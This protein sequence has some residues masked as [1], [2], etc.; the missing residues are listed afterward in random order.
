MKTEWLHRSNNDWL[1]LF[2]NG[3][4]MDS[5]PFRPLMS[6][7]YDVLCCYDYSDGLCRID[8]KN[9]AQKYNRI[10]LVGW[11]MGVVYGQK[12][13]ED[14]ADY[15][16]KT[17]AVNGTLLPVDEL[18]GIPVDI[19][20]ATLEALDEETSLKFYRRMFRPASVFE[21]FMNNRPQRAIDDIKNELA[22]IMTDLQKTDWESSIYTDIL[23]SDKDMIIPTKNQLRFWTKAKAR[24]VKRLESGHFPFYLWN[25]WDDLLDYAG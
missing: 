10:H 18:Y 5:I 6:R 24:E 14:V 19:C 8:I 23:I 22:A 9:L 4:G 21:T 25:S 1:I 17:I 20:R 16:N 11:S 12:H 15:F 2:Y 13:F 7:K 3:W